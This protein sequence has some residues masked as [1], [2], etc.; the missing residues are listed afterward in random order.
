MVMAI[1]MKSKTLPPKKYL[2][3]KGTFKGQRST[4]MVGGKKV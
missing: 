2:Q 4:R 3:G 1:T